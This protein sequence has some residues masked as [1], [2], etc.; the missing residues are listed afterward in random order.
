MKFKKHIP[1]VLLIIL[2]FIAGSYYA[3]MIPPATSEAIV[4][5]GEE[6]AS[7]PLQQ[8]VFKE[9]SVADVVEMAQPAVVLLEVT[10]KAP[11]STDQSPRGQDGMFEDPFF[12]DFFDDWFIYP[13]MGP[14][15]RSG[16][17]FIFREDGYILTN[18]HLVSQSDIIDKIEV[19]IKGHDEPLEAELIGHDYPLDLAVLK[20]EANGLPVL[21]LGDSDETRIGETVVAIGNPYGYDH[22]VTKGVLSAREREIVIH[23]RETN[24][25][26]PY[27]NLM[28]TD[29]AINPGNSGGP[30]LNAKGQ[31][32]G[33]NTAVSI[34]AQ[35]IGFAIPINT[36]KEVLEDLIS[37]GKIIRPFIGVTIK[38]LTEDVIEHFGLDSDK[39]VIIEYVEPNSAAHKGGLRPGDIVT[40]ID[41]TEIT[42][43]NHFVETIAEKEVGQT[44][45]LWIIRQ[46]REQFVIVRVG[47]RPPGI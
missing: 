18:Q 4:D 11:E 7:E 38:N 36:A 12:R 30:L 23:D 42:D 22:T 28:Q 20:V 10:Y 21:N 17:G 14:S 27:S 34:Q 6:E 39:G 44:T 37:D 46:G 47:E 5:A 24:R 45:M 35:G 13:D 31:V 3:S 2:S 25:Q 8:V 29:A 41:D 9:V 16:T 19:T 26:R 40:Q 15:T 43:I 32:V 1:L 33:I